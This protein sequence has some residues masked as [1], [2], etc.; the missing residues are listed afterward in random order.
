LRHCPRRAG[1]ASFY[2]ADFQACCLA[3]FQTCRPSAKLARPPALPTTSGGT[4]RCPGGK[5]LLK[6]HRFCPIRIRKVTIGRQPP[7]SA[8]RDEPWVDRPD[9]GP[10]ATWTSRKINAPPG[11]THGL[12]YGNQHE[13]FGGD[14]RPVFGA[15]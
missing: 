7:T 8:D 2:T 5:E 9:T 15:E 12:S 1:A 10:P 13:R 6:F 11:A 14:H 4:A 3:G